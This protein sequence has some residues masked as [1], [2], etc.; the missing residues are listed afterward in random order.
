MA[1]ENKVIAIDNA[2]FLAADFGTGTD[3]FTPAISYAYD[4]NGESI[5]VQDDSTYPDG[6]GI[7][8]INVTV[9][10]HSG[11][12]VYG[13]IT[14]AGVGG[15]ITVDVTTLDP[16]KGFDISCHITTDLRKKSVLSAYGVG[17]VTPIAG[18]LRYKNTTGG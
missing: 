5:A 11:A 14:V 6:D 15:A 1:V 13:Q 4:V 3:G 10:D 9:A 2:G 7:A 18:N 12:K 16:Y 17:S 8:A